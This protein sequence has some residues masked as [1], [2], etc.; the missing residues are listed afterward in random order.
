[1]LLLVGPPVLS[2]RVFHLTQHTYTHT[3]Q[4]EYRV[5]SK[6]VVLAGWWWWWWDIWK[7]RTVDEAHLPPPCA[8]RT[9]GSGDGQPRV[10]IATKRTL[11][12][13]TTITLFYDKTARSWANGLVLHHIH[14]LC[15]FTSHLLRVCYSWWC[16]RAP[17]S[18]TIILSFTIRISICEVGL[19]SHAEQS[20]PHNRFLSV[21]TCY[22]S[23]IYDY[24]C[25]CAVLHVTTRIALS[26][27]V[28]SFLSNR[29]RHL[30][31]LGD[32]ILLQVG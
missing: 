32:P 5:F 15:S 29:P 25:L 3:Q 4:G 16:A 31:Q 18:N 23:A 19:F 7:G 22:T 8:S 11:Y 21:P 9:G 6:V 27:I 24:V 12:I 2:H 13:H 28:Y 30:R 17:R 10:Y 20:A 1:M 26:T 14:A